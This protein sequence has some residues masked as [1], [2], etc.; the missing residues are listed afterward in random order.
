MDWTWLAFLLCPLMM[1]PMLFMMMK[2]NH[3]GHGEQPDKINQ[4]LVELRKQNERMQQEIRQL[5]EQNL[6]G[7]EA[8]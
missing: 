6:N 2:G 7:G 1:I 4:E 8:T 3:S 5:K